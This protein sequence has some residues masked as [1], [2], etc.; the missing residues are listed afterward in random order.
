MAWI[1]EESGYFDPAAKR[2]TDL[3]IPPGYLQNVRSYQSDHKGT[4]R[5]YFGERFETDDPQVETQLSAKLPI[6]VPSKRYGKRR[7]IHKELRETRRRRR[8]VPNI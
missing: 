8:R 1:L 7:I 5:R 6:F 4:P 3:R 2:R